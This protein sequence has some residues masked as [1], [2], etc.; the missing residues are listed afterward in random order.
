MSK[1][2][3]F[4]HTQNAP[5]LWLGRK[6]HHLQREKGMH[7]GWKFSACDC[8]AKA[9]NYSSSCCKAGSELPGSESKCTSRKQKDVTVT[10]NQPQPGSNRS[11]TGKMLECVTS[12]HSVLREKFKAGSHLV[13]VLYSPHSS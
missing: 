9:A 10:F 7:R 11:L 3:I 13:M 8:S 4:I 12:V 1:N 2:I 5:Q 6:K